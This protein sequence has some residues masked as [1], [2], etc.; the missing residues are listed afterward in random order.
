MQ[1]APVQN[2]NN[3]DRST[4]DRVSMYAQKTAVNL[5]EPPCTWIMA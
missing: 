1:A 3:L 5:C 4:I 2:A